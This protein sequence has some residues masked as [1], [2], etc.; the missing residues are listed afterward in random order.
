MKIY[1]NASMLTDW[2]EMKSVKCWEEGHTFWA[3]YEILNGPYKG[4]FVKVKHFI[5]DSY[6]TYME[7]K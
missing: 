5:I 7:K 3:I 6:P 1:I 2:Y 4:F